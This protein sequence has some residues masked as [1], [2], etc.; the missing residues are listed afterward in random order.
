[1][2]GEVRAKMKRKEPSLRRWTTEGASGYETSRNAVL[3]VGTIGLRGPPPVHPQDVLW[4]TGQQ[5][6]SG[7]AASE[8]VTG[9]RVGVAVGEGGAD[10]PTDVGDELVARSR[11][12]ARGAL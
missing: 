1:M 12:E 10:E 9:V 7:A 3:D 2:T 6:G 11:G 4:N 5:H 8:R